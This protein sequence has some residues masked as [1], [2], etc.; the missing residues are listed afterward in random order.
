M[1]NRFKTIRNDEN[2]FRLCV[3]CD[4][5]KPY[6]DYYLRRNGTPFGKMCKEC[7]KLKERVDSMAPDVREK[8]L[9]RQREYAA[10][11]KEECCRRS[12]KHYEKPKAR[13]K[14]MLRTANRRSSKFN[15]E[16]DLDEEFLMNLLELGKCRVT[17]IEFDMSAPPKGM[18]CN[19]YSPS[20]DRI[21]SSIGYLKSNVRLVIWQYN[22]MKGEISDEEIFNICKRVVN[23]YES[24]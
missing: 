14:S 15:E 8:R 11:H 17:G 9:L 13:V 3:I 7:K 2:G 18:K 6:C 20:I 21:D 24:T 4:T 12:R 23:N 19:P 16:C 22:L 1:T 10:L 5:I